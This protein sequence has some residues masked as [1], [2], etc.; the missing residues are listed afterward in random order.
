MIIGVTAPVFILM[1]LEDDEPNTDTYEV[2]SSVDAENGF[3]ATFFVSQPRGSAALPLS[4]ERLVGVVPHRFVIL[5]LQQPLKEIA[6][7]WARP[8]KHFF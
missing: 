4:G 8:P 7:D 2:R 5:A 3:G 6:G 1:A